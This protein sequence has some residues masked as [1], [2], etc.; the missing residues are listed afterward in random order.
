MN[1]KSA[2]ALLCLVLLLFSGESF[3]QIVLRGE[4]VVTEQG[5]LSPLAGANVAIYDE[6]ADTMAMPVD[7]CATREDGSFAMRAEP[8]R[9]RLEVSYVGYETCV[10]KLD[11]SDVAQDTL[12]IGQIVLQEDGTLISDILVTTRRERQEIDRRVVT[13][14]EEQVRAAREARDL[15]LNLPNL[16]ID[17]INNSLTTSD[18]KG[19]LILING[20]RSNNSELKL[21]PAD[22]VKR[23][24]YY[25]IPPIQ[26]RTSGRVL[27]VVTK[28]LDAGW[29]GDLYVMAAQFFS[30]ATPYVSYVSGASRLTLGA[31]LFITPK[32]KVW[33][34]Y[35]G[36]Y[37]YRLENADYEYAYQEEE[38]NWG[39]QH[40]VNLAYSHVKAER[41]VVQAK[42]SLGFTKD[43][44]QENREAR[45]RVAD[46]LD[47]EN[48]WT[49]NR[50]KTL[51]PTVDLYYSRKFD[52]R[53]ELSFN[54]VTALYQN[55][56]SLYS[57][58]GGS[59]AY[60]DDSD[61]ESTKKTLIGEVNYMTRIAENRLSFGYRTSLSQA[62]NRWTDPVEE[63]RERF[64]Q[65]E[66]YLYGETVGKIHDFSYR[67]SLG[68]RLNRTK[69]ASRWENQWTLI[70]VA[71]LGGALND[72]N[73][74]R[75]TYD[76]STRV[77]QIQQF[78]E[79][80][81]MVMPNMVRRGNPKLKTSL[82]HNLRLV[83]TYSGK[84]LDVETSLFYR[85]DRHHIFRSFGTE[86]RDG[87]TWI[88]MANAN[89]EKNYRYGLESDLSVTP[90]EGVR[91]GVYF[92]LY[93]HGFQP[94]K[95]A[96]EI[97]RYFFPVTVYCSFS[98]KNFSLDY[99][100]KFGGDCLDGL[101]IM[102]VEKVSYL[103][104]GYSYKN[105]DVQLS[106]YFPFVRNTF[107]SHTLAGSLVQHSYEAWL[108]NKERTFGLSATWRFT[109]RSKP[110][111]A[112]RRIENMDND[113]GVFDIK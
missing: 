12:C 44:F 73:Y 32:R 69:T 64:D 39:H 31:D 84:W 94:D 91:L 56:Q 38:R 88:V 18:G 71:V 30:M 14:S 96:A 58:E 105:L 83:H 24:E 34:T 54:F 3:S 22:K 42:A 104:A 97:R 46:A 45:Y 33:D 13:F 11:L 28:D 90:V 106:Y 92:E 5:K 76:A 55:D 10:R 36:Q 6:A 49:S 89:A 20:V 82:S 21:I 78:S 86:T 48:G 27:N 87:Q 43:R 68:G 62:E 4:V 19:V 99:S 72:E 7:V 35:E 113:S 37:N 23:V 60:Q 81:I 112:N 26:Y 66:H 74:L 85:N 100:Q 70:P 98:Y 1:M 25:D 15:M 110:Y 103:T 59:A 75:L 102:G 95:Q 111:R 65:Q 57:E 108:R 79:N 109:T 107:G 51:S 40:S 61:L 67:I 80:A 17:R 16:L 52:R 77:P 63:R 29:S 8:D 9:Y 47:A 101:Y 2:C 50:V 53:S 41:H 93:Q